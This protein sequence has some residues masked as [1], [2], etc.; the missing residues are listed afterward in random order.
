M[1]NVVILPGVPISK[2][3]RMEVRGS[4]NPR[5]FFIIAECSYQNLLKPSAS[6][7]FSPEMRFDSAPPNPA[8]YFFRPI[9][10]REREISKL[11][12]GTVASEMRPYPK[13]YE[14]AAI[15]SKRALFLEPKHYPFG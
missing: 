15:N 12:A 4:D 2:L 9:A 10:M 7:A 13:Q 3:R 1:G 11:P 5:Y 14:K 8:C 6:P